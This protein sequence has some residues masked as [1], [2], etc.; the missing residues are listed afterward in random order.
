MLMVIPAPIVPQR[1]SALIDQAAVELGQNLSDLMRAAGSAL[2]QEAQTI[3]PQGPILIAVGPGNNGGDGWVCADVLLRAGRE[4]YVWEVL[5]PRTDLAQAAAQVVQQQAPTGLRSIT[6]IA[7]IPPQ[8][9]PTLIIDAILGAGAKGIPR[10]RVAQALVQLAALQLPV[11]A[12][13]IPTGIGTRFLL[14][15]T[16]A[17]CFQVAKQECYEDTR[18]HSV[19]VVSI[20]VHAD[21]IE[22]V[23]P[24]VSELFP[25][26]YRNG[27]KGQHGEVVIV[28][29]G[30]YPGALSFACQAAFHTGIDLVRAWTA[31]GPPLPDTVTAHRQPGY[32]LA[33][34]DPDRLSALLIR[35]GA[36]LIGPGIGRSEASEQAAEQVFSLAMDLEVPMILDADGLG[37]LSSEIRQ[38]QDNDVPILLTPHTG[39][40]RNLF[41]F[42]PSQQDIHTWARHNRVVLAKGPEDFITDGQQWQ[43]N[44]HGNPRM[45]V[46]GTGDCLAGL[47][48]GF[49]A[50]GLRPFDAARLSVYWL[51]TAAD[52]CWQHLGPCYT[53]IDILKELPHTLRGHLQKRGKWPPMQESL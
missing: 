7:D 36:V 13:D 53:P 27:H 31:E 18:L 35:A 40:L 51:T 37:A 22:T 30:T 20:G 48:A 15:N 4:V 19:K 25:P 34:Y 8:Q 50:R 39:E 44:K 33:P 49:V 1:E 46:G 5:A 21:A 12:A 9:P 52:E 32:T 17:L 26:L 3:A 23:Q 28:G 45:A 43:V 14:S 47:C 38:L 16:T 10:D 42:L 6:G 2:A 29:G 11:L 41:S 24:V